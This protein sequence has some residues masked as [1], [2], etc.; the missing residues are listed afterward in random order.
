[1]GKKRPARTARRM[2]ERVA[3]GLVRDRERLWSLEPG[4]SVSRPIEV[5]SSAVIEVKARATPCPQCGARL[6]LVEHVAEDA[7]L[8]RLDL[9]CVQCGVPRRMWF[10]I[11]SSAN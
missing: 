1:V 5:A 4:G 7:A 9:R 6:D 8:R 10:R 2:A 3:R 11:V